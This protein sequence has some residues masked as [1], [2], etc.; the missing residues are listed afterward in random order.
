GSPRR[1]VRRPRRTRRAP[2]RWLPRRCT[3]G[4]QRPV[5]AAG[6]PRL[7]RTELQQPTA[8]QQQRRPISRPSHRLPHGVSNLPVHAHRRPPPG[9][10]SH[11]PP[12][13]RPVLWVPPRDARHRTPATV[14]GKRTALM[15]MTAVPIYRRVLPVE[16]VPR[17]KRVQPPPCRT[18][19]RTVPA[20]ASSGAHLQTGCA[21]S[22]RCRPACWHVGATFRAGLPLAGQDPRRSLRLSPR[23]AVPASRRPLVPG[24]AADLRLVDR[25]VPRRELP[26]R[27]G[28]KRG[29]VAGRER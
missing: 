9:N 8:M 7:C 23:Q 16:A 3:N 5:S 25:C 1:I 19:T 11:V 10:T 29:V 24:P 20:P 4:P 18:A 22:A 6:S 21:R 17:R 28:S 15:T 27:Q 2:R 26:L 14:G 13:L 12:S